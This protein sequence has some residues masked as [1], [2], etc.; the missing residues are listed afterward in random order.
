MEDTMEL[1]STIIKVE[2]DEFT[3]VQNIGGKAGCQEDP[4]AFKIMRA[5]Q[6][7]SWSDDALNSYLSDLLE[8]KT[9]RRN[10]LTEKYARMMKSTSLS[11]YARIEEHL[12]PLSPEV[13]LLIDK[14]S[15]IELIWQEDIMKKFPYVVERG[16]PLYSRQDNLF[17]TSFETYLRGELATYS[18]KTLELYYENRVNQN[19]QKING[20]EIT[21]EYTVK[22]YGYQSLDDAN[23]RNDPGNPANH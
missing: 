10:L 1:I 12:P 5:S 21:L 6:F 20:A 18:K 14:I 13:T 8:A 11:E 4:A 23:K 19:S 2:W 7:V 9:N 16:R 22:Q 15:E 17:A 3:N